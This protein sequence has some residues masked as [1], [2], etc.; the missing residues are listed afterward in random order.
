MLPDRYFEGVGSRHIPLSGLYH[1]ARTLAVYA[2][3]PRSPVYC[4]RPRKTR[5]R[6]VAHLGRTG[7]VTARSPELGPIVRFQLYALHVIL[8]TQV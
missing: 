6:L 4:L 7:L 2:S 1:A 5:F 3:R 8:L